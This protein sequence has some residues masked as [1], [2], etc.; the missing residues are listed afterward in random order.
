MLFLRGFIWRADNPT[1]KNVCEKSFNYS[2]ARIKNSKKPTH[3][4]RSRHTF[5]S[6]PEPDNTKHMKFFHISARGPSKKG[7]KINLFLCSFHISV[8]IHLHQKKKRPEN[9]ISEIFLCLRFE[10]CR[11]GSWTIINYHSIRALLRLWTLLHCLW[12]ISHLFTST[13]KLSAG[14]LSL[15]KIWWLRTAIEEA[16]K[17][18]KSSQITT[19]DFFCENEI[20]W[21]F[22]IKTF[23]DCFFKQNLEFHLTTSWKGGKNKHRMEFWCQYLWEIC[24]E[25][26]WREDKELGRVWR[27][28]FLFPESCKNKSKENGNI[29]L[30][31]SRLSGKNRKK[32]V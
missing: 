12:I 32:I 10:T 11:F 30:L 26:K 20:R 27:R 1:A 24:V 4:F 7:L 23:T 22:C 21:D 14:I 28:V 5:Q 17:R 8:K 15:F 31:F 18:E 6:T 19:Q 13:Q 9:F 2:T 3:I 16:T 29:F 25:V